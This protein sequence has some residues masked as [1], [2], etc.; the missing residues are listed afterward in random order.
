MTAVGVACLALSAGMVACGDDGGEAMDAVV[1]AEPT[2]GTWK[3]WVLSSGSEI[4]VPA[5]PAKDSDKAK[6]DLDAVK[7]AADKRT[8]AT[9]T[10]VDRWNGPL[11]TKPWTEAMFRAIEK[12]DKNPPL[13]SRNGALIHI[14]MYDALVASYHWKYEY[15]VKAPEGVDTLVPASPDPSYP[16]EHAAMAPAAANVLAFVYPKEAAHRLD[17]MA[18]E[19]AQSRIDAGT[20]T[21]SDVEAGRALGQAVADKVIAY[22]KTDGVG[23]PWNG[24]RPAGI[25]TGPAFWNPPP[26]TTAQPTE[27][28]AVGWKTWTLT[29][30]NQFRP[31]PPPAFNS[32]EF[33]AAAQDVVD[34][35]KNLTEDQK[36]IAKFWEGP[37]GSPQPAGITLG[38]HM[39]DIEK[40]AA[41]GDKATRWTLPQAQRAMALLNVTMHDGGVAVW[42]AKYHYWYPRPVNG[43]R[44]SGVD[45][46]WEPFVPTPFF[47]AYPSGS[48]GYAG[49]A[50][51]IMDYLFPDKAEVH[52]Q[53]A[54]EQAV[55]RVYAGIHW[56]F[57]AVS[58]D[59]GRKISQL[60]IDKVK[61]D[62]VGKQA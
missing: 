54:E 30:N 26:G 29:S 33:K 14:A 37:A 10:I 12:S 11:P 36:R 51:A 57:D 40:A 47:P 43:V 22:A 49:G 1:R 50:Q 19:A 62:S 34:V 48:A 42:E 21:P 17:E 55:A 46:T 20:N 2:A 58:L 39:A 15:N 45:R 38:V 13:S 18:D 5:P 59:G 7:D 35:K 60:V 9:K 28:A 56:R 27:P 4:Q 24:R 25:G 6:A 61:N 52:K 32:A 8:D 41:E 3:T 31:P 53:R 23:T 16:S 44:D